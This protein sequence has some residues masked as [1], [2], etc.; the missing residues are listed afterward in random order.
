MWKSTTQSWHENNRLSKMKTNALIS[1]VKN[2]L[3]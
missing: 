1:C 2:N 3:V